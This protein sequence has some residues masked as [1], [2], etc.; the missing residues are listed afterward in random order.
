[1]ATLQERYLNHHLEIPLQPLAEQ[2]S[3]ELIHNLL[4]VRGLPLAIRGNIV[5]RAGG[6]P[7]FLRGGGAFP[8][9]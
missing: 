4:K 7:F 3:G 1:V 9:R 6:N 2:E 5:Q 8:D